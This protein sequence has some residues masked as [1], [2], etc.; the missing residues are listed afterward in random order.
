[1]KG[2]T[3]SE[4]NEGFHHIFDFYW[5]IVTGLQNYELITKKKYLE[6]FPTVV[7]DGRIWLPDDFLT[8]KQKREIVSTI[9]IHQEQMKSILMSALKD[10]EPFSRD[11]KATIN[12]HRD[13]H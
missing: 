12:N 4:I 11:L 10:A 13:T 2:L 9:S 5:S 3:D 7:V 1:M 8:T 6:S